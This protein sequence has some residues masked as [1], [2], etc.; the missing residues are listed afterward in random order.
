MAYHAARRRTRA[1]VLGA[2]VVLASSALVGV[3]SAGQME[4][5]Q[6]RPVNVTFHNRSAAELAACVFGSGG[7]CTNGGIAPGATAQVQDPFNIK[8][9]VV[10]AVFF[11]GRTESFERTVA[12]REQLCATVTDGRNG[13]LRLSVKSGSC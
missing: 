9:R 7:R 5:S 11:A 3:A 12:A 8:P 1:A 2:G 6:A 13:S 4:G 10:V